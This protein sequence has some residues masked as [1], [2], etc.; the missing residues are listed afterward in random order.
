MGRKR[1]IWTASASVAVRLARTPNA[2][3][4]PPGPAAMLVLERLDVHVPEL[5]VLVRAGVHVDETAREG[6][7]TGLIALFARYEP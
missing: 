2:G 5:S 7:W 3:A 6:A 1:S 4:P